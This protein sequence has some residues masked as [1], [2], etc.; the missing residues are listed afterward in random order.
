MEELFVRLYFF[1]AFKSGASK[2]LLAQIKWLQFI[3]DQH[4][5]ERS[6]AICQAISRESH[7][8]FWKLLFGNND[9]K[10]KTEDDISTR[11]CGIFTLP[12]TLRKFAPPNLALVPSSSSI[13]RSWLYLARRSDLSHIL[14]AFRVIC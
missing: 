7:T 6:L 12:D 1:I 9:Q 3:R 2:E 5:L 4:E 14:L 11:R 10:L 13:L 8:T